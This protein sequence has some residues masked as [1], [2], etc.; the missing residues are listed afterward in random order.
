MLVVFPGPATSKNV[1]ATTILDS[2][3][4]TQG[5]STTTSVNSLTNATGSTGEESQGISVEVFI[6]ADMTGIIAV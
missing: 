4:R 2:V 1:T 3:N 5:T 6:V